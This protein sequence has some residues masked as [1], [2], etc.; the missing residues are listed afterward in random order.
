MLGCGAK[1]RRKKKSYVNKQEVLGRTCD[2]YFKSGASTHTMRLAEIMLQISAKQ[3][4][5]TDGF[6]SLHFYTMA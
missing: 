6:S 3:N 2:A 5:L 1:E 4:L